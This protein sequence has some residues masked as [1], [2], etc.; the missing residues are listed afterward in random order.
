MFTMEQIGIVFGIVLG[1]G[2]LLFNIYQELRKPLPEFI[3]QRFRESVKKPVKSNWSIRILRPN[4][5]I[6]KCIVLCDEIRLPWWDQETLYYERTFVV[7]GGGIVRIPVGTEKEDATIKIMDGK[8][9]L[10][11]L[12]F[13]DITT[14]SR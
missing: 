3:V 4:K 8:R 2:N 11:H 14:A 9:T 7:G 12:K 5:P 10:R 13:K 1:V 6:E